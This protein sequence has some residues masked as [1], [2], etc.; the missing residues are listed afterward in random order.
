VVSAVAV[1]PNEFEN[2]RKVGRQLDRLFGMARKRLY[3]G[4]FADLLRR[5]LICDP[6]A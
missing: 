1:L 2:S 3:K 4:A 6:L 5:N